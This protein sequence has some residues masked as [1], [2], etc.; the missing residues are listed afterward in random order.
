LTVANQVFE[1][2][3]SKGRL[4]A[5]Q[6]RSAILT[7]DF[8]VDITSVAFG[9]APTLKVGETILGVWIMSLVD[10]FLVLAVEILHMAF[11]EGWHSHDRFR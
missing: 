10:L 2:V 3:T 5:R 6:L 8:I 11:F 7:K 1:G 4:F 9:Y